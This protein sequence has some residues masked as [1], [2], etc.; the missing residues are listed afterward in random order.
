MIER[1]GDA[2][3]TVMRGS[4]DAYGSWN[5]ICISRRSA[6][7]S[8]LSS[9]VS[10]MPSNLTEPEVGSISRSTQRPTVDFPEPDSPTSPSVWPGADPNDTPD[11]ACTVPHRAHALGR[12]R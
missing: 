7:R 8:P 4:S 12:A 6:R 5:T 2:A 1:L 10:S 3:P 11:T 9:V